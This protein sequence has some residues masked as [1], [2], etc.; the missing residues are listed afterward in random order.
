MTA[1]LGDLLAVGERIDLNAL[2]GEP[3]VTNPAIILD[4]AGQGFD[5][6]LKKNAY[7]RRRVWQ[8][9]D[10]NW[11]SILALDGKLRV[12]H[13]HARLGRDFRL[14]AQRPLAIPA[15]RLGGAAFDG[16]DDLRIIAWNGRLCILGSCYRLASSLRGGGWRVDAM[17]TRMFLAPLDPAE[18]LAPCVFPPFFATAEMDKNWVSHERSEGELALSIDFNRNLWLAFDRFPK[19]PVAMPRHG[20]SWQGGWSGSSSLVPVEQ[21]YIAILHRAVS[22]NP[23]VYL[24]MFVI[25]DRRFRVLSRSEPFTFEGEPVEFCVGLTRDAAARQLIV[26]Y[27]VWDDQARIVTLAEQDAVALCT[28]RLSEPGALYKVT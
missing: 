15:L 19:E 1:R 18:G 14:I 16:A 25:C 20:L 26:A 12:R 27:G 13:V 4:A 23:S 10:R 9:E 5:V 11:S 21:G 22:M 6:V 17:T 8:T 28:H 3:R 7:D 2:L 24:H